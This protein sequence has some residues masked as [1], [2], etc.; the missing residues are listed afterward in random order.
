MR[1]F[2]FRV[3]LSAGITFHPQPTCPRK[4]VPVCASALSVRF[5]LSL[6][7]SPFLPSLC[8]RCRG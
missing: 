2:A 7:C 5:Y 1:C 3:T 8:P 4:P 6:S